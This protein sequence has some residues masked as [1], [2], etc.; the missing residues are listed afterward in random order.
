MARPLINDG[1]APMVGANSILNFG[2]FLGI[3]YGKLKKKLGLAGNNNT[4]PPE[5]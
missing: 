2:T 3:Q 4:P 1:F 5:I